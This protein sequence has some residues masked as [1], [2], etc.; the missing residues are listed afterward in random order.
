MERLVLISLKITAKEKTADFNIVV[1]V[2]G[3]KKLSMI[4]IEKRRK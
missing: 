2:G 3:I 1:S 4:L